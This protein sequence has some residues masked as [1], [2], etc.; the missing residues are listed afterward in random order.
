MWALKEEIYTLSMWSPSLSQA[1]S[2]CGI[3]P[4]N[5]EY[6]LVKAIVFYLDIVSF[7]CLRDST[8]YKYA[9]F[10]FYCENYLLYACMYTSWKNIST[11]MGEIQKGLG[12]HHVGLLIHSVKML[13]N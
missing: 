5:C 6:G 1:M 13:A 2:S 4:L 3:K 7:L 8:E 11:G 12:F 10:V 9:I